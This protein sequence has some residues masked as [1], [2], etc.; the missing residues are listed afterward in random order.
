MR[1]IDVTGA[2][3]SSAWLAA[4]RTMDD[5]APAAFHT[6][7][8][9]QH[10]LGEDPAIRSA[11]DRILAKRGLQPV[12]TV[13]NTIFPVAVAETSY[14]HLELSR[15]YVKMLPTLKRLAPAKNN[16]GTYF[17]R[18][19]AFP[20]AKGP[21]NQLDAIIS[22]LRVEGAK[23]GSR[24]GPLTAAYEAGFTDPGPESIDGQIGPC[25][26]AVAPIR[27][28]G[29]D[30]R[31]P[32]FP[33]LSYCSFQV[34]RDGALHAMA[35]Y[36]SQRMAERAY[37]NYLGLGQLLGYI[38]TQAGLSCGELTVTAGYAMLDCRR[39]IS[40]LVSRVPAATGP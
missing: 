15:R 11:L 21:V 34:D 36:R 19:V 20:G 2:D 17:G 22:R 4:C 32:G 25:V 26:T 12:S 23:K 28:P 6:V 33:C 10:P 35:H 39:D 13:A 24:T 9:I 8:R 14:D 40:A 31:V 7:V 29:K 1:S 3:I 18:L 5:D 37:G 38:A 16:Q 30:N 27:V